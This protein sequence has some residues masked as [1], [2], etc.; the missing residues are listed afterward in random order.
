MVADV[1]GWAQ[2]YN[3]SLIAAAYTMYDFY[4]GG[5]LVGLL[6]IVYEFMLLMK[7]RSLPLGFIMGAMF[8]SLYVGSVYVTQ[9]SAQLIFVMLVFELA[10]I[11]YMWIWK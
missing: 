10:G 2:L 5:W 3:G 7:T 1:I 11:A 8:A 6:F 4:F 9:Y